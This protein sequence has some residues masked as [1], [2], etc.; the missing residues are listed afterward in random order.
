MVFSFDPVEVK[1]IDGTAALVDV[2]SMEGYKLVA[3]NSE[4]NRIWNRQR[5]HFQFITDNL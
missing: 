5:S 2:P 3:K 4:R 1:Q